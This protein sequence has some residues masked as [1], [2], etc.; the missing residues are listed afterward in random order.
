M[1]GIPQDLNLPPDGFLPRP[2]GPDLSQLNVDR[3]AAAAAEFTD[4]P[5]EQMRITTLCVAAHLDHNDLRRRIGLR[6]IPDRPEVPPPDQV[7][8][9]ARRV[10]E[11]L[12]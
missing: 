11:T 7:R 5:A 1:T 2:G 3:I 8:L 4:D 6:V 12:K 10:G 9:R